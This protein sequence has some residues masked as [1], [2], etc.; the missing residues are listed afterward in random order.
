[1]TTADEWSLLRAAPAP[2]AELEFDN[3]ILTVHSS[4]VRDLEHPEEVAVLWNDIM[5]AI[6]DLAA[7]PRKFRRKER[8]VTDVQIS[9]GI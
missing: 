8:F 2:W 3:I 6:S 5:K 4:A 9:H 1:M 7:K